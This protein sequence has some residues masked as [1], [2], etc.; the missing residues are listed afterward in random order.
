MPDYILRD[1]LPADA[2]PIAEVIRKAFSGHP[3]SSQTEHFIVAALRRSGAL[4]VSLV[5]ESAGE[6]V[7]HIAFSPVGISDGSSSWYGLGPVSVLPLLQGH[8][9]GTALVERGLA[10]LRSMGASG[11]VLLGEPAFYARFGFRSEPKL[12]LPGVPPGY[13]QSLR[14]GPHE[15]HGVVTYHDAF[16]ARG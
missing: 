6:V 3:H 8:G 4:S 13:F 2:G 10:D 12:V 5:A 7:G 11:C 15:A 14:F 1:E 16:D 9:I